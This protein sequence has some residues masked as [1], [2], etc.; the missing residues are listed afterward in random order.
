MQLDRFADCLVQPILRAG[1]TVGCGALQEKATA[2]VACDYYLSPLKH[3]PATPTNAVFLE[4]MPRS[5]RIGGPQNLQPIVGGK[6]GF[7]LSTTDS[8]SPPAIG[9]WNERTIKQNPTQRSRVDAHHPWQLEF[10]DLAL[11]AIIVAK[12]A[13]ELVINLMSLSQLRGSHNYLNV[14]TNG[15]RFPK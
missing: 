8:T 1:G 13:P 10:F 12:I 2:L 14:R 11:A 3:A 7:H 5:E 9:R 4:R 6:F 15:L